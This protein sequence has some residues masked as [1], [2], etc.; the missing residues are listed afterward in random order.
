MLRG[1]V[2]QC[3]ASALALGETEE[4]WAF[5]DPRVAQEVWEAQG[6]LVM[7]V[8]PEREVLLV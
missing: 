4:A 5:Q 6:T 7:R 3:H 8:D 2:V 1:I